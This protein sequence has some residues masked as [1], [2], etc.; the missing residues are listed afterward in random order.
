MLYLNSA[1]VFPL[2]AL[3]SLLVSFS[4]LRFAVCTETFALLPSCSGM[5]V[6][7]SQLSFK[8]LIKPQE[9]LSLHLSPCSRSVL[10]SIILFFCSLHSCCQR[11]FA[12]PGCSPCFFNSLLKWSKVERCK[13]SNSSYQSPTVAHGGQ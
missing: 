10:S 2:A 13:P 8:F 5:F 1:L 11:F 4:P 12:A 9:Q 3:I 7:S 6:I